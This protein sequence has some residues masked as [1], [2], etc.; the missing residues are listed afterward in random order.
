MK[1]WGK[2]VEYCISCSYCSSYE[3]RCILAKIDLWEGTLKIH[4]D[5]PF[6]KPI[7]QE[8]I[9][10]FGF[11]RT[12]HSIRDW[13]EIEGFWDLPIS[14][15]YRISKYILQH[16]YQLNGIKI[17]GKIAG[18]ALEDTFYEGK[19]NNPIELEFILKSL[20]IIE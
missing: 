13:Y 9:E 7:T 10:S 12:G 19:C 18:D 16:D 20:G 11:K 14:P 15:S 1:V 6:S 4:K 2:E 3:P 17:I 5:C 8:V